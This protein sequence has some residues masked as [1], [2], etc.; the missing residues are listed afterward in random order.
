MWPETSDIL[1]SD[2]ASAVVVPGLPQADQGDQEE[3]I[4]EDVVLVRVAQFVFLGA[5]EFGV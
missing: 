5:Y 1:G 2:S 3:R 4:F